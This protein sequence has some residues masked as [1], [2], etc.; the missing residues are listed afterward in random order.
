MKLITMAVLASTALV[1][2]FAAAQGAGGQPNT[3]ASQANQGT[4]VRQIM[5]S[6]IEGR[7]VYSAQGDAIGQVDSVILGRG[8]QPYAVV[9]FDEFLGLGGESRL[10]PL[11]RMTLQGDRAVISNMSDG[12]FRALQI[13][14]TNMAG[15]READRGQQVA[16]GGEGQPNRQQAARGQ[17]GSRIVLQQAAPTIRVDPADPRVTVRQAQPQVTV[18]QAQ[19]EIIVRQPQPTVRVDIP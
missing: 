18:N 6:D 19:P 5:V 9:S 8:N 16:L 1:P 3:G 17:G 2:A 13:Y 4:Q 10:V 7:E 14:R 15:F 11:A 12:D